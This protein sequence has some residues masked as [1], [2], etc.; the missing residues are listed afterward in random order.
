MSCL[1][2]PSDIEEADRWLRTSDGGPEYMA[3][4][5]Y[6]DGFQGRKP[7]R[8]GTAGWM[9]YMRGAQERK[10]VLA[11]SNDATKERKSWM[12][13]IESDLGEAFGQYSGAFTAVVL[14]HDAGENEISV[15]WRHRGICGIREWVAEVI[16]REVG[17]GVLRCISRAVTDLEL[18]LTKGDLRR[19]GEASAHRVV[20][21]LCR[22][23][24][25]A[26]ATR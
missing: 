1:P 23:D 24:A 8:Y 7:P 16:L 26:G 21:D 4:A 17:S 5:R 11:Q 13:P 22:V 9:V 19:V 25:A 6:I 12:R 20:R 3:A 2:F 14:A 18:R 15:T 10:R